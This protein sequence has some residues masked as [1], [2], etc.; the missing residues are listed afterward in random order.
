[1]PG[2]GPVSLVAAGR[3]GAAVPL[4]ARYVNGYTAPATLALGIWCKREARAGPLGCVV[5]WSGNVS[6]AAPFPWL[7]HPIVSVPGG[8]IKWA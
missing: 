8:G 4:N 3:V 5:R 6:A 7:S 1:M 2:S